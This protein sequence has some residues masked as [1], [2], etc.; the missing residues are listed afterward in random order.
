MAKEMI[1]MTNFRFNFDHHRPNIERLSMNDDDE[2][3]LVKILL[4]LIHLY[5]Q[6]NYITLHQSVP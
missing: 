4:H 5:G 1:A 2:W 6:F 3:D